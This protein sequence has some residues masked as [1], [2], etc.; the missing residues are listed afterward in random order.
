MIREPKLVIAHTMTVLINRYI[1]KKLEQLAPISVKESR[2]ERYLG[3][4]GLELVPGP[5]LRRRRKGSMLARISD[6][7]TGRTVGIHETFIGDQGR[8]RQI[9]I[10]GR[11]G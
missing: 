3:R 7:E 8:K 1:G 10:N 9:W 11:N 5:D 2:I 4:R 6:F